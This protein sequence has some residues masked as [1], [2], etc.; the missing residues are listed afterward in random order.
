MRSPEGHEKAA[1]K[2]Y[3]DGIGAWYFCPYMAGFGKS[4]VPD[5][6]ACI[7]GKFYSF[8]VKREGKEPTV[9]QNKRMLEI[10]QSGG[11]AFAGTA[12]FLIIQLMA[13]GVFPKFYPSGCKILDTLLNTLKFN[14]RALNYFEFR[15]VYDQEIKMYT[16]KPLIYVGQ[17]LL[18]SE[19][20]LLRAPNL[21]KVTVNHIK[22][23]LAESGLH[24]GVNRA[25]LS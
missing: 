22:E 9:I 4:G 19:T 18:C 23:V 10:R 6:I 2:K 12:K 3:L 5:I 11:R 20:E 7:A 24:L 16:R 8:E 15:E 13:N 1:I 17:L 25:F 21:G 14:T